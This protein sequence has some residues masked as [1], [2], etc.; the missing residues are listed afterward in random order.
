MGFMDALMFWKKKDAPLDMPNFGS[1]PND[2]FDTGLD[3]LGLD[4][5]GLDMPSFQQ[6]PNYAMPPTPSTPSGYTLEPA[7]PRQGNQGNYGYRPDQQEIIMNK[8]MEIISSKL[9]ALQASLEMMN[10]R[11]AHI[12]R[13]AQIEQQKSMQKRYGY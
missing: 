7:S 1:L 4:K 12:E 9:D 2:K 8:N 3:N 11:I 13:I 6:P 10:Q 5:P